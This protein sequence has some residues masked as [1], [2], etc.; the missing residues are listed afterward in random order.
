METHRDL[1]PR[2]CIFIAATALLSGAACTGGEGGDGGADEPDGCNTE[3]FVVWADTT[4][5]EADATADSL[6]PDDCDPKVTIVPFYEMETPLVGEQLESVVVGLLWGKLPPAENT[7]SNFAL[8]VGG[9]GSPLRVDVSYPMSE[10]GSFV[11]VLDASEAD[12]ARFCKSLSGEAT[13]T[14]LGE[15]GEAAAGTYTV[16]AWED[17]ETS[18][19]PVPVT[20]SFYGILGR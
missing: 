5:S 1:A 19:P 17:D 8:R 4:Y 20:G 18:C 10:G 3:E 16:T 11:E 9:P 13:M 6:I 15:I 2:L 7:W 14:Q 12:E